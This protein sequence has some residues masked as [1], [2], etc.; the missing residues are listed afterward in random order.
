MKINEKLILAL[1]VADA[2]YAKEL[3]VKFSSYINIFK[4]GLELFTAAGPSIIQEIHKRERKVFLDLKFHDI[5]NTV[6]LISTHRAGWT[7]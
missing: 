3:I 5:P 6:C 1:D 2:D 4:V 7:C